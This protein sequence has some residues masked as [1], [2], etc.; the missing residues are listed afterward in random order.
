[1]HLNA[2]DNFF[3]YIIILFHLR[4]LNTLTNTCTY[5]TRTRWTSLHILHTFIL[6]LN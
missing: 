1:M 5:N 4:K 2:T 6:I 3:L